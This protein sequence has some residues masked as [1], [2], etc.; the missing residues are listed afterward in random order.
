MHLFHTVVDL[1]TDVDGTDLEAHTPDTHMAAGGWDSLSYPGAHWAMDFKIVDNKVSISDNYSRGLA[2]IDANYFDGQVVA[3]VKCTDL[4]NQLW[5]GIVFRASDNKNFWVLELGW[6]IDPDDCWI[7]LRRVLNGSYNPLDPTHTVYKK[8]TIEPNTWYELKAIFN[9]PSIDGY[10]NGVLQLSMTSTDHE[11]NGYI[12]IVGYD[13]EIGVEY[14]H[15][16]DNFYGAMFKGGGDGDG[17]TPTPDSGQTDLQKKTETGAGDLDLTTSF[18]KD[19]QLLEVWFHLSGQSSNPVTITFDAK[20]GAVY[21]T[22]LFR[23]LIN[24]GTDVPWTPEAK[25]CFEKGDEL[26]IAWTN[27]GGLTYGLKVVVEGLFRWHSMLTE[28]E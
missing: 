14:V 23:G 6:S 9:G 7:E 3:N 1:F 20:E 4:T 22:V 27:D 24:P 8:V 28:L 5:V 11:H 18:N 2:I 13:N 16:W 10:L 21:D 15:W 12:G 19:F 25:C 26:R 17:V